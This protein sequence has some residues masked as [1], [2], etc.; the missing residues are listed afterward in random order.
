M[1]LGHSLHRYLISLKPGLTH[2]GLWFSI[3]IM[4]VSQ[5]GQIAPNLT[6]S[7]NS[8]ARGCRRN[9]ESAWLFDGRAFLIFD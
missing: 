9:V 3:V 6:S 2:T 1:T 5:R 4:P 8:M 7:S